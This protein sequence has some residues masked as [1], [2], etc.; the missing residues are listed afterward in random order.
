MT[1]LADDA[2][3]KGSREF[4]NVHPLYKCIVSYYPQ[5][6]FTEPDILKSTRYFTEDKLNKMFGD[7]FHTNS[8]EARS[9][10]PSEYVKKS[11]PPVLLLHGTADSTISY[12]NSTYFIAKAKKTGTEASLV[13]V[14]NG[15]HGFGGKNVT[16]SLAEYSKI[17]SDFMLDKLLYK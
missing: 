5:T 11:N 16:P 3:F 12:K 4:E 7:G 1:G 14:K 15:G 2:A 17:V 10:S 13:T 8:D 6:I 9:V